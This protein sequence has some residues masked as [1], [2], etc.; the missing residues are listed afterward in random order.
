MISFPGLCRD[1]FLMA[2]IPLSAASRGHQWERWIQ[3]HLANR[4]VRSDVLPGGYKLLGTSSLS[5]LSHQLDATLSSREAIVIGEWKAY[6]GFFPKNELIRFK[7]VTD[8]YYFGLRG[9]HP[10]RSI[11]RLFGG[12]G[13]ATRELRSYAASWG[14]TL[15]DS[16]R[17]PAPVL[18]SE[19]LLWPPGDFEAPA[20]EDRQ[21]LAWLSRPLQDVLPLLPDGDYRVRRPL[22]SAAIAGALDRHDFWS[23]RLWF[24]IDA[25]P[26]KFE[27]L[28]EH[29]STRWAQAA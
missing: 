9:Q 23:E 22:P 10:A 5:G 4:G 12:P 14:I 29:Y 26:G 15:V 3:H 2:Q 25:V 17:W 27:A 16:E 1:L 8:D 20:Q 13:I 24:S 28:I 11:M 18:A 19:H 7:A 6:Q 21:H